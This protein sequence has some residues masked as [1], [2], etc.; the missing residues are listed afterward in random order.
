MPRIHTIT[1]DTVLS[2]N[3]MLLGT[4]GAVGA[5]NATKNFSFGVFKNYITSNVTFTGDT[6][7]SA[8]NL[9]LDN[10]KFLMSKM[11]NGTA[12]S[13]IGVNSSNQIKL[14][15]SNLPI[16]TGT[17]LVSL[18]GNLELPNGN[19]IAS[20]TITAS[21]Y[22]N[23][24]WNAAYT[25]SQLGHLPLTGGTI[26]GNM[27]IGDASTDTLSILS[28]TTLTNGLDI[29]ANGAGHTVKMYG[30]TSGKLITFSPAANGKLNFTDN[31][32]AM[33]GTSDDLQIYHNGTA[34]YIDS[35]GGQLFI[36]AAVSD[37]KMFFMG[38]DGNGG[39]TEYF[40]LD[41]STAVY[42]GNQ[43]QA[44]SVETRFP[45]DAKATFGIPGAQQTSIW[46]NNGGHF[47]LTEQGGGDMYLHSDGNKIV[48][49]KRGSGATH[50]NPLIDAENMVVANTDGSVELYYDNNK[51][52]ETTNAGIQ[53]TGSLN[54]HGAYSFPIT[55]GTSGQVLKT[56]GSGVLAF[57][58]DAGALLGIQQGGEFTNS[59]IVGH[60]GTG[61][62]D[63]ALGNT[64]VGVGAMNAI[65]EG[66]GNVAV[67][68]DSLG[69]VTVGDFNVGVGKQ[70]LF[71]NTSSH[72]NVAV[73]KDALYT[74]NT[75]D[76]TNY[77]D[78]GSKN[79]AIGFSAGSGLTT[80]KDNVFIGHNAGKSFT[81]GY[82]NICIGNSADA[83]SSNNA[84]KF[85]SIAIG[86]D[87]KISD[88]NAIT[89]GSADYEKTYVYALHGVAGL[90]SSASTTLT[91]NDSGK[92]YEQAGNPNGGYTVTLPDAGTFGA[93]IGWNVEIQIST[94]PTNNLKV[95]ADNTTTDKLIGYVQ[96]INAS[97]GATSIF[98]AEASDNYSAITFNGTT[99][100][101]I[102]SN[103]KIKRSI[104]SDKFNI[105]GTLICTT[106]PANPFTTT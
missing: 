68:H 20:G 60:A 29:G 106:T 84:N 74:A 92:T 55:D 8:G 22:N 93:A 25:Y 38:D 62:L 17:G 27:I 87:V 99:Q 97:T 90:I 64:G 52:L 61:T 85:N 13:L 45:P 1:T 69:A 58:N 5:N 44:V 14:S 54:I 83:S 33:F 101:T 63:E 35:N 88:S 81:G 79:T 50:Q 42:D 76:A 105:S 40:Y 94:N 96:C 2:D 34:N 48:I 24:N 98:R 7:I 65:T 39:H 51:K 21:G 43:G 75:Q 59:L 15:N 31:T 47:Y 56:N 46:Q 18:G 9:T 91:K 26:T 30:S 72:S 23:S 12:A 49:G 82:Q 19:I 103:V 100:G 57:A 4:D 67:G 16:Y 80:G 28:K 32:A 73:G 10:N 37:G 53:T 89:I 6:I 71:T 3:D 102:G 104:F 86:H 78:N 66:D 77:P 41:G 70:A 11:A 95:V 36:R